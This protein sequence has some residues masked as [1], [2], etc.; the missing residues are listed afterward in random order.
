MNCLRCGR[1]TQDDHVF[2]EGCREEME[3]YPVRPGTAVMLPRRREEPVA[4]KSRRHV[5]AVPTMEEQV[6]RLKHQR[7]WLGLISIVLAASLVS[8]A[9][10][11]AAQW[12]QKVYRPGQNYSAMETTAPQESK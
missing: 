11:S 8:F 7:F 3:K 12:K 1:E 6:H 5:H 4:K 2:C 10:I 9:A